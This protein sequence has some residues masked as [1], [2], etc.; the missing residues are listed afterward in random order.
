[1]SDLDPLAS[2]DAYCRLL[3][4]RHYENFT[5]AS[6][7]VSA[8]AQLDLARIYAY[9]RTTDDLG[10]E[11]AGR[12]AA[13]TRLERWRGEVDELFDGAQPVHPVLIALKRTVERCQM[14]AAPFVDLIRAN[15]QDQ[16]VAT[17]ESWPEL[18][19]YCR[20][21]A[22]PVGRMVLAVFGIGGAAAVALSDDVC[23]GLQLANFAQDVRVDAAKG[24]TY[25]LQSEI[26]A[27]G[28]PGAVRAHCERARG[29]LASGK[30][31]ETMAPTPL[32]LQL[33]LYRLGGL[34]ITSAIARVG[35]RTDTVRP[36]VSKPI[37]A[38]L[39]LRAMVESA[40]GGGHVRRPQ[41]A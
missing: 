7:F 25:L 33:A 30:E 28:V 22:A 41:T 1:M 38:L 20:W 34:A 13:R 16:D 29:L 9:C 24:R 2:A 5:V 6:R 32:R 4:G 15:L 3:A 21:S 37:K 36:T 17:Y 31:L 11:S 12:D 10:D 18:L 23:I 19:D 8:D 26:R 39:M 27:S 14:S 35:Y 40:R